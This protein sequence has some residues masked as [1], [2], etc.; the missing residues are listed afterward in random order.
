MLDRT[1]I[2]TGWY[3]ALTEPS[4]ETTAAAGLV[5]RRFT[6]YLPTFIKSVWASR[7]K[8]RKVTRPLFPGYLFVELQLGNE[9]WDYVR[10]VPGIR[11]FLKTAGRPVTVPVMALDRI[12]LKEEELL[13]PPKDRAAYWKGKEIEVMK[14]PFAGFLGPIERMNGR[15]RVQVMLSV[16]GRGVPVDLHESEIKFTESASA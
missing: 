9:P 11:E 2:E 6:C 13:L 16:F 10:S 8:R 3:I 7:N 5:G 15:D 12:K 4:R 14:G 1:R